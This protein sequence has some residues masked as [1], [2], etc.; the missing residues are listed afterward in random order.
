MN[1]NVTFIDDLPNLDELEQT[2]GVRLQKYIR[3]S[4]YN[5]PEESGMM[6]H[7]VQP[8]IDFKPQISYRQPQQQMLEE[9]DF[10]PQPQQYRSS[11]TELCCISV[12]EHTKNCIVCSRLYNNDTTG[13]V[14]VIILLAILSIILMKRVLNV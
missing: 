10:M 12:A 3:N 9:S 4:G 1:R 8:N 2:S 6:M 7:T 14:V 5:P 13:H 11:S